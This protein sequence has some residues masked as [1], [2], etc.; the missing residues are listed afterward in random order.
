MMVTFKS[1]VGDVFA[2]IIMYVSFLTQ[3]QQKPLSMS[4]P[5]PGWD[6]GILV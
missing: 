4:D 5:P 2:Q 1:R 6:S 3:N